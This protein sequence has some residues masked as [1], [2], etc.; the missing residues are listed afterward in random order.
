MICSESTLDSEISET[1]AN[2]GFPLSVIQT[3]IANKI[4]EFNK[5]K[6]A[7][8]QKCPVYLCLLWLVE[9]VRDLLSKSYKLY[10]SVIFHPMYVWSFTL[11]PFWH[12]SIKMFFPLHLNN[13]LIYLFRSSCGLSCIGRANERLDAR[14]KYV[15]M[16]ICHFIGGPV[17]NLRNTYGYSIGKH[18]I[19]NHDCA[20]KFSM[21]FFLVLSKS[22]SS[23]HLKVLETI[24]I[25]FSLAWFLCLIA[26][27]PL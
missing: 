8:V 23:F 11:N 13:S 25:L 7:S 4:T 3:V 18:L 5:P 2:N 26:Y 19:N 12:L 22:H 27:Q 6:Q 16:K 1:L 10:R 9:L 20:E 15:P 14:I 24:H 21:D 17:D